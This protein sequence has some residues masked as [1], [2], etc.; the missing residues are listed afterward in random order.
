MQ[1]S[2]RILLVSFYFTYRWIL[3]ECKREF[4]FNEVLRVFEVMW[5]TLPITHEM[6]QLSEQS[7]LP[8]LRETIISDAR[9]SILCR[10]SPRRALSCPQLSTIDE[11]YSCKSMHSSSLAYDLNEQLPSTIQ[12]D[13]HP[14]SNTDGY[15]TSS[16]DNINSSSA[17]T[18]SGGKSSK[19]SFSSNEISEFFAGNLSVCLNSNQ[20]TNNTAS[21]H[22]SSTNWI[23]RLPIR[24][25]PCLEEDNPFLLFLCIS[26]LLAHRHHLM[27]QKNLDE[28]DIS[29]HFDRYRRRHN[30]EKLLTCARTLYSQY[31]QWTKQ[32]RMLNDL[33][34]FSC[35]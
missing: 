23:Q 27:K 13:D 25:A 16:C 22:P 15:Q 2:S 20:K 3:L 5:A 29:M 21:H 7:T 33:T 11:S 26:I 12:K 28:Q 17:S 34:I 19:H 14:L 10:P 35:S 1:T 30:A 18:K 9:S 4:P 24:D 8:S 31:I 6:L 32:K